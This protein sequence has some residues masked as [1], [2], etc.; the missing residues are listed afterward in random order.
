MY[1]FVY[2]RYRRSLEWLC[3]WCCYCYAAIEHFVPKSYIC[4]RVKNVLKYN[5]LLIIRD[6]TISLYLKGQSCI[7]LQ[8][9][10][11]G[12]YLNDFEAC[13]VFA[14]LLN[15]KFTK[16]DGVLSSFDEQCDY[17]TDET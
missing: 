12:F 17:K 5:V 6:T 2:K 8:N 14:D 10:K 16:S 15:S 3:T 11:N 7:K 13:K 9:I 4:K 1:V